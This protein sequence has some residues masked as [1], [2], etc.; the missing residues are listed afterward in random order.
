MGRIV[1]KK[2]KKNAA[3]FFEKNKK[4]IETE[5]DK[6]KKFISEKIIFN[7]KKIKNVF[8]G[9]ITRLKRRTSKSEE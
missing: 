9:Y 5:F 8:S 1:P 7:S 2:I 6:N 3:S 4:D